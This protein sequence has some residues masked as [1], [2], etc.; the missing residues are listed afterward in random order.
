MTYLSTHQPCA[1]CGS[2]D[3]LT[4]Y[5]DGT[6]YCFSCQTRKGNQMNQLKKD[7]T[8]ELDYDFSTGHRTILSRGI[9]RETCEKYNCIKNSTNTLFGYTDKDGNVIA[10]KKRTK[11]KEFRTRGD[12][13]NGLLYGQHLFTGGAKYV[14]ITEGEF[15]AMATYQMLGSRYPV[16]SLKNGGGSALKDAKANYEWLNSFDNIVLCLDADEVGQKATKELAELLDVGITQIETCLNSITLGRTGSLDFKVNNVDNEQDSEL[17]D[18]IASDN[19]ELDELYQLEMQTQILDCL[20]ILTE[21]ERQAVI[22]KNGLDNSTNKSLD[23]VGKAFNPPISRERVRQL[24]VTAYRKLR[25]HK[26]EELEELMQL[27]VA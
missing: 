23:A 22:L 9:S 3:A 5:D 14:T 10:Y 16:V 6:S 19:I 11:D 24:L 2:S 12:W 18:F 13:S 4:Y 1:D 8:T 27:Y 15:D 21:K 26:K 17:I 7:H 25:A 20:E